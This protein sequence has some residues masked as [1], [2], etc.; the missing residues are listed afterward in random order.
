MIS[1]PFSVVLLGIVVILIFLGFAER[2]LARMRLSNVS[3]IVLLDLM[4][5][6]HFLPATKI[7]QNLEF[8]LG[9]LVPLGVSLYLL[10]T[11][12]P[13]ERNIGILTIALTTVALWLS[14]VL[15]SIDP[16]EGFDLDPLY[17]GAVF[18]VICA[19]LL[20]RSRR[21]AFISA[22]LGILLVDLIAAYRVSL[23]SLPQTITIGGGGIFDSI[24]IGGILAVL[25]TEAVGEVLERI[26]RGPA[27]QT[28]QEGSDDSND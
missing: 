15:L 18:A 25:L 17:I 9:I 6:A 12:S 28:N 19:Y 14:D 8:K 13:K 1:L 24:V 7:T 16:G 20:D 23:M 5:L 26:S 11:T 21:A 10:F 2:V 27:K 4:A 22:T 3:A